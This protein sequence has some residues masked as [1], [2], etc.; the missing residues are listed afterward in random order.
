LTIVLPTFNRAAYLDL[1]LV[2]ALDQSDVD[3]VI[4]VCDNASSDDTG[5]VVDRHP[6]PRVE[7]VRRPENIGWLRNFNAALAEVETDYVTVLGD[8]DVMRPGAMAR[9]IVALDAMPAAG[10]LHT[11]FD[12]IDGNGRT[13]ETAATW[14]GLTEDTLEPGREF[15]ERSMGVNCRVSC[16]SA[17]MRTSVLPDPPF[18][19]GDEPVS[20]LTLWLRVAIAHDVLYLATPG[21]AMRTHESRASD[22]WHE[23]ADDGVKAQ[24]FESIITVRDAKLRFVDDN[25][26]RLDDVRRLRDRVSTWVA[27]ELTTEVRASSVR[28]RRALAGAWWRAVRTAPRML[29][30]SRTWLLLARGVLGHG[31][32]ERMRLR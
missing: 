16:P 17:V 21:L 23:I 30:R 7:Y 9:A 13:L 27:D 28:G 18:D 12:L 5:S 4:K 6:D 3:V 22:A 24:R 19:P 26:D 1:A 11:A 10:F 15:I 2:S 8:D 20:D 25:V 14:T 32:S 29:L 31:L